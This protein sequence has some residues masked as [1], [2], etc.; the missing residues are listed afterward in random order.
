MKR[1]KRKERMW[2]EQTGQLQISHLAGR[3]KADL[4]ELSHDLHT[5]TIQNCCN[6]THT[7][8]YT[9]AH[10]RRTHTEETEVMGKVNGKQVKR[11][12]AASEQ[13]NSEWRRAEPEEQHRGL[14][15][16]WWQPASWFIQITSIPGA[17]ASS[18]PALKSLFCPHD[19]PVVDL[20]CVCIP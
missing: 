9:H 6:H 16:K 20:H 10:T 19:H 17:E 18:V 2:G 11:N 15:D 5:Q 8:T 4:L 12:K 3:K 1:R 13:W 7:H 14:V